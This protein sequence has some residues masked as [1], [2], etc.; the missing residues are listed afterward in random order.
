MCIGRF[1]RTNPIRLHDRPEI[2]RRDFPRLIAIR[3]VRCRIE[4]EG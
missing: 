3:M 4:I 2:R 1:G